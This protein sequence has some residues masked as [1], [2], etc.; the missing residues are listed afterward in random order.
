LSPCPLV[1]LPC[2]PLT[3]FFKRRPFLHQKSSLQ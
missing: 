1:I 2:P 3:L